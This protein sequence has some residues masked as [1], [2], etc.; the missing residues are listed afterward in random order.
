MNPDI[1]T[2]IGDLVLLGLLGLY[3]WWVIAEN[4]RDWVNSPHRPTRHISLILTCIGAIAVILHVI[5][6]N[7]LHIDILWWSMPFLALVCSFVLGVAKPEAGIGTAYR[8]MTI[9]GPAAILGC[10]MG[11]VPLLAGQVGGCLLGFRLGEVV[12][13][14][15][16]G[17]RNQQMPQPIGGG[18]GVPPPH[19]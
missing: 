8:F 1:G 7:A 14:L 10:A 2:M 17:S 3:L 18:D 11:F 5:G 16:S 6:F 13:R 15:A 9:S 4:K 19:R 12:H